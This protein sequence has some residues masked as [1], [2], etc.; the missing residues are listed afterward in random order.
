MSPG[1]ELCFLNLLCKT[2]KLQTV[3]SLLSASI[4]SIQC[5]GAQKMS[6]I[7]SSVTFQL[8]RENKT[9]TSDD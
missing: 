7:L 6:Q 4:L 3:E 2:D 8:S 5:H 9:V 1:Q